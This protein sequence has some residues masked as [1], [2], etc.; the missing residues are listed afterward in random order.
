MSKNRRIFEVFER[1]HELPTSEV[2][3]FLA[4]ECS[5]DEELRSHVRRLLD[6]CDTDDES[7]RSTSAETAANA[8]TG[9]SSQE[10]SESR[11]ARFLPGSRICDRYQIV[12]Q[13][14]EGAMGEVYRADDLKLGHHVAIKILP[15]RFAADKQRLELF[16]NE[17][18]LSRQI[19]HPNVCRVFDIAEH[20]GQHFLTM[21]YVD[22]EDLKTLL[23]RIGRLPADKGVEISQ[24]ICAGLAAAHD[25]NV[26]HRDLKPA[27]IMIDGDGRA[28]ITD[29]GLAKVIDDNHVQDGAGTPVYMAP[30]QLTHGITNVQTE[31]YSLG[32]V[33]HELFTGEQVYQVDSLAELHELHRTTRLSSI[34]HVSPLVENAIQACLEKEPDDRARSVREVAATLPGGEPLHGSGQEFVSPEHVAALGG[35]GT[36]G[37]KSASLLI[38][39]VLTGLVVVIATSGTSVV[40]RAGL[41]RHPQ[42]LIDEAK[43]LISTFGYTQE[44][45]DSD[46]GL[47]VDRNAAH[48]RSKESS[49]P[50]ARRINFWYRSSQGV[51]APTS[52][53]DRGRRNPGYVTYGDPVLAR[54]MT[55]VLLDASGQL[56]RL[57]ALPPPDE[58]DPSKKTTFAWQDLMVGETAERLQISSATVATENPDFVP[59]VPFDNRRQWNVKCTDG[60]FATVSAASLKDKL[61]YYQLDRAGMRSQTTPVNM[62]RQ[63]FI[64]LSLLAGSAIFGWYHFWAGLGD[65][66]GA[67]RVAIF[68]FSCYA[69]MCFLIGSHSTSFLAEVQVVQQGGALAAFAGLE[70]WLYY[71]AM[72]PL[73][74]RVWPKNLSSWYRL[75]AGRFR[76]PLVGHCILV[77]VLAA[78]AIRL[79]RPLSVACAHLL[80]QPEPLPLITTVWPLRGTAHSIATI[81]A[82]LQFSVHLGLLY[83]LSFVILLLIGRRSWLALIAFVVLWVGAIMQNT[84]ISP[85]ETVFLVFVLSIKGVVLQRFGLLSLIVILFVERVLEWPI[86]ADASSW[87]FPTGFCAVLIVAAIAFWSYIVSIGGHRTLL[88]LR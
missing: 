45:A 66:N 33:L 67:K 24:Q 13:I 20:D 2:D 1:A 7:D 51:L 49:Q 57:E 11:T 58:R 68:S 3:R 9:P 50:H 80:G 12:S 17:V 44:A 40:N 32:L 56:L 29:F 10:A 81:T 39:C 36:F 30:E 79:L 34:R 65:P 88:R 60:M 38:A 85:L 31:V 69:L 63:A 87:Y 27:N 16:H 55:R 84:G 61:V 75:L 62:S 23:R 71:M 35:A 52:I 47:E 19:G 6:G 5:D 41:T 76:D 72:E 37:L 86:T 14:G 21:E 82:D 26:I 4:R 77:G 28:K 25:V 43:D 8:T 59:S 42:L 48:T 53:R 70:L 46:W 78:V 54:G 74:R 83:V 73:V 18:R 15:D 22:G 64:Y